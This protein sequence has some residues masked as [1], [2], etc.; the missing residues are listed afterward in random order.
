MMCPPILKMAQ[1]RVLVHTPVPSNLYRIMYSV[2]AGFA[3]GNNQQGQGTVTG[4]KV[5]PRALAIQ[6]LML[7]G[8]PC[9]IATS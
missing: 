6:T 9:I 8:Y 3:E 4:S 2:P 7:I 1:H 5:H